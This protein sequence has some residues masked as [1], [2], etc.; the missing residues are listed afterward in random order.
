MIVNP[1]DVNRQDIK[2]FDGIVRKHGVD[3]FN[4][5]QAG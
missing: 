2:V 4:I 1:V 5:P 3:I